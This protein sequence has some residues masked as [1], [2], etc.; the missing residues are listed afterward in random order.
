MNSVTREI[1]GLQ[2]QTVGQM[3]KLTKGQNGL[4]KLMRA[5]VEN[6]RS[7]SWDSIVLCYYNNVSK[8]LT[9]K[10]YLGGWFEPGGAKYEYIVHD[11][12][13]IYKE[14]KHLWLYTLR[15]RIRQW[16]VSSIGIL[17]VKNQLIVIPTIEIDDSEPNHQN[18]ELIK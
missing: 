17:V 11:V 4:L 9:E 10:R 18:P 13:D 7:I 2:I 3:V 16:F 1:K 14:Q 15:A 12:L 6:N 5:C 8:T